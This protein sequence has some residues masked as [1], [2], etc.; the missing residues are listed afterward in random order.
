MKKLTNAN[1]LPAFTAAMN[2]QHYIKM[3]IAIP[4]DHAY[5]TLTRQKN[6]LQ[7]RQH[8]PMTVM[9]LNESE[10]LAIHNFWLELNNLITPEITIDEFRSMA[11]ALRKNT[12]V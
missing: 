9:Y 11:K 1:S 7:C 10:M 5:C 8:S 12:N 4:S 6:K 3:G 2:G